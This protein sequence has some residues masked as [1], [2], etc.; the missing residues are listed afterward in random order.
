MSD[1][2]PL[3]ETLGDLHQIA[4]VLEMTGWTELALR[5]ATAHE[6][7]QTYLVDRMEEK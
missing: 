2:H 6:K 7:I 4:I 3:D 5:V 1:E